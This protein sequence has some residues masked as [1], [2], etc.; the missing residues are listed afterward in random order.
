MKPVRGEPEVRVDLG[1]N[2]LC[3]NA[4]HQLADAGGVLCSSCFVSTYEGL[5]SPEWLLIKEIEARHGV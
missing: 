2:P 4:C 1:A 3:A 5:P